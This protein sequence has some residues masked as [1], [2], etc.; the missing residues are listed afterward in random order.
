MIAKSVGWTTGGSPGHLDPVGSDINNLRPDEVLV[1]IDRHE[2]NRAGIDRCGEDTTHGS[3]EVC[4]GVRGRVMEAGADA[5]WFV[6]RSVIIPADGSRC[7]NCDAGQRDRSVRFADQEMTETDVDGT[8]AAFVVVPARQL[9]VVSV[10][11]DWRKPA[12]T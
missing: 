5:L 2:A 8:A 12:S 10:A 11:I 3:Q 1:R 9:C 6:D 7:E 4:R